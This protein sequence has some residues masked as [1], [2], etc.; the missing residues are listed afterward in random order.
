MP[1]TSIED[2]CKIIYTYTYIKDID[3]REMLEEEKDWVEYNQVVH[4]RWGSKLRS[5]THCNLFMQ[6]I[7]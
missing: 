4:K 3:L 7:S 1:E 2:T 6:A 5:Q